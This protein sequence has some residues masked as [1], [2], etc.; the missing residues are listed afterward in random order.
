MINFHYLTRCFYE[1]EYDKAFR[2]EAIRLALTGAKSIAKTARNLG[3]K[4]GALYNEVNQVK[5]WDEKVPLEE[6]N[7]SAELVTVFET[8]RQSGW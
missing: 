8:T 6:F 3:M 2:Q 5:Q 1:P 7:N 4:A